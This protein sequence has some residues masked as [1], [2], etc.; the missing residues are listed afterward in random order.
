M[1]DPFSDTKNN[2]KQWLKS[3]VR[4]FRDIK[5]ALSRETKKIIDEARKN[6]EK[7]K[8]KD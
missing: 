3:T 8:K 6:Y 1:N 2:L 5:E 7:E 4:H